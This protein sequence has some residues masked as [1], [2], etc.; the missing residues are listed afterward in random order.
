MP[1]TSAKALSSRAAG[2]PP[3]IVTDVTEL[4][5]ENTISTPAD[6]QIIAKF[7]DAARS[8]SLLPQYKAMKD[9]EEK[10]RHCVRCHA[11]F[12]E[13]ANQ[14]TSCAI[15]H[16]FVTEPHMTGA[17]SG[18][19]KVYSYESECC[20]SRVTLEEE[21]AGNNAWMNL[22]QLGMC[23]EGYHTE[24][25]DEVEEE[26]EYNEVNIRLCEIDEKSGICSRKHVAGRNPVFD[27]AFE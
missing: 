18:Y 19:E 15:P 25:V 5:G 1:T 14:E 17:Y 3:S 24:D 23:Y 26:E 21:G 8:V 2:I 13:N 7:L 20:G 6:L 10:E 9:D 16:A 4:L 22:H 12:T 27:W 11:T